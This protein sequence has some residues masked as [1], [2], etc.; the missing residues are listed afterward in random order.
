MGQGS[1]CVEGFATPHTC[2]KISLVN[3]FRAYVRASCHAWLGEN[4]AKRDGRGREMGEK[5]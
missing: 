5:D 3:D 4:C 1:A 2:S